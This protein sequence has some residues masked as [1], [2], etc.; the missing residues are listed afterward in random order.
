MNTEQKIE[1]P[2]KMT[3]DLWR[4]LFH[5]KPINFRFADDNAFHA[6]SLD[7]VCHMNGECFV[8]VFYLP[9]SS[10]AGTQQMKGLLLDQE[11]FENLGW[12]QAEN[13]FRAV[14]NGSRP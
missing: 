5:E 9:P 13:C 14:F 2:V 12:V 4:Q 7:A 10:V 1:T 6:G 3:A 8:K 11:M